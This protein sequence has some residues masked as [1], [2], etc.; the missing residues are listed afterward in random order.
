MQEQGGG[1]QKWPVLVYWEVWLW[2]ILAG[3]GQGQPLPVFCPGPPNM[4]YLTIW[5]WL[6]LV[7][8]LEA[9]RQSQTDP[10]W[11]LLVLAL[12]WQ[13]VRGVGAGGSLRLAVACLRGLG[14]YEA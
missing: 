3:I 4:S 8:G 11:L 5:R 2:D 7:W 13:L 9:P 14:R 10:A 1:A 6:L 12:G